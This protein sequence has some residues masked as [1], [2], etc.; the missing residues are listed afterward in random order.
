MSQATTKTTGSLNSSADE[1]FARIARPHPIET[2][3]RL[4][5]GRIEGEIPRELNGTLY[6]NGPCQ[7]IAPTAGN[8]ALHFFDGDALVH[9]IDFDEG[10][11]RVRARFARTESFERE[12][13]EGVYC[14]RGLNL[15]PD[16]PLDPPM[17]RHAP[18]TNI[19]P[20]AGRLFALAENMPPF[21]MDPE[22]LES[23][24]LWT[25]DDRMLGLSTTAHPR[26]DHETGQ[27]WIHGYQPVSPEIQLYCIES[28]GRVSLAEAHD[29]PWPSMMHDF[30][31][32]ERHVIFPL[33]SIHFDLAPLLAGERFSR[34]ISGMPE[35]PMRFGI[36][37]REAGSEI[38]WLE[39]PAVGYLFHPGNAYEND[40]RI[41]MD[42]CVYESPAD[43]IAGLDTARA[44]RGLHGVR[45]FPY[46]FEFD[47]ATG[48]CKQTK[49]S[50]APAEFPRLD[51][52]RVG[53]RNRFGYA[54]T[55]EPGTEPAPGASANGLF[56]RLT[57]Y[58]R[59]DGSAIHRPVVAGQ[60]SGEPVFVPRANDAAEDDGF[61]LNLLHD[62]VRDETAIEIHDARNLAGTPLARGWLEERI[63]LGF[64]G[65]WLPRREH[66]A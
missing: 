27:M 57:R 40:G 55:A 59:T 24:G 63:P 31:I 26:L 35:E 61:V 14:H 47:L 4:R 62:A 33:G 53:R 42:A 6:R 32:S 19:V 58:D 15:A 13:R 2:E 11:V 49:L 20:H 16:R 46:L 18:N 60:W 36:R 65:N 7:R 23:R 28:D 48:S 64:H 3:Y 1:G 56:R 45:A 50:D 5:P 17:A 25:L 22:S 10:A 54:V 9:A 41:E 21:E 52:R 51:D 30:A 8:R 12:A 39:A 44:G 37:R 66:H 43:L 34:V 29:A 38:R